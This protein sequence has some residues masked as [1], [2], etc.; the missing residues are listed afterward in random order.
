M[1]MCLYLCL[2]NYWFLRKNKQTKYLFTAGLIIVA[3][4]VTEFSRL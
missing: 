3:K 2:D 4:D 1:N